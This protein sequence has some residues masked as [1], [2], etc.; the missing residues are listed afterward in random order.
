MILNN[1]FL[2]ENSFLVSILIGVIVGVASGALFRHYDVSSETISVVAYP[3]EIFLRAL[4]LIILPF[5]I[6][7]II[8]GTATLN[9]SHNKFIAV[10]VIIYFF[11]TSLLNVMLGITLGLVL[12]PGGVS[13]ETKATSSLQAEKLT[14]LDGL[15]D[16]GRNLIPENLFEAT[17]Q[18]TYTSY[19]SENVTKVDGVHEIL[20]KVTKTRSST[21]TL[22]LIFFC[23]LFGCILGTMDK[24]K[25]TMV[26]FFSSIYDVLQKMLLIIIQLTPICVASIISSKIALVPDLWKTLEQLGL[27]IVIS[28][29]GFL[30][31]QLV[32]AQAIYFLVVRKNPFKYYVGIMPAIMTGFATASK[33]ASL[34]AMFKVMEDLR[35]NSKISQFV[36]PIGTINLNGSA[37]YMGF[38]MVFLSQLERISLSFND[39]ITLV[40]ACTFASMSSAA[41]PSAAIVMVAMLCS[42]INIPTG[43]IGLLLAV[44]WLI[45][46]FR[47]A[48]N[49]LGDCYTVAVVQQLSQKE[50]SEENQANTTTELE[51]KLEKSEKQNQESL[52]A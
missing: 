3:G 12:N 49:V 40:F 26:N 19:K 43:N 21:N 18:Q 16:V 22:G 15:L 6:C 24:Q 2:R 41:V 5:I 36:L 46:R 37:Q 28:I 32:I 35:M 48:T 27:F 30:L 13:V 29:S 8:V 38:T 51:V 50:L 34:P 11:L 4:K 7:C 45:D 1:K 25:K 42:V 33:A 52:S 47:T 10:R 9:I 20:K 39:I 17:F 31:Y 14:L 23:I 44:D